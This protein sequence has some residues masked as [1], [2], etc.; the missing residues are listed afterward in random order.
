MRRLEFPVT[1]DHIKSSL[2]AN[3]SH[4]AIAS[5]LKEAYPHLKF[6]SVDLQ[7]IRATDASK[8]ERYV[9]YT[10]RPCQRLIIDFDQGKEVQPIDTV[11][12]QYGQVMPSGRPENRKKKKK[13]SSKRRLVKVGNALPI[14]RGGKAPPISRARREYGLRTYG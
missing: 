1:P 6:V 2:A 10:P 11:R 7:T 8:G 5:A 14:V 12:L 13:A 3:S 9:W 4:C